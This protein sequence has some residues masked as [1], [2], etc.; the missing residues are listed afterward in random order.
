MDKEA[1]GETIANLHDLQTML[2]D[3]ADRERRTIMPGYTHLQRAQPVLLSHHLLAYFEMFE[4]DI[5]RFADAYA[6]TDVLPLGAGALAGVPYP[7][8]AR[9]WRGSSNS[10]ASRLTASTPFRDRDFVLEYVAAASIAMVH[11]SRL[12]EEIVLW[13]TTEFGFLELP[14]AFATGS[15]IMPQKK[16]PDV[17]EL[18]RGRSGRVIGD[19]VSAADDAQRPAAGLQ[20]RHAGGQG[21]ALRRARYAQ[22]TLTVLAEMIA[23]AALPGRRRRARF[24]G[25]PAGYRRG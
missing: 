21:A 2:V 7:S 4:R 11:V 20:P 17:A 9:W 15:S 23:A 14:D 19:L 12:A 8:T 22:A 6:R 24:G 3:L 13:S 16:N 18:A 25:F 5:G 10:A 1:I